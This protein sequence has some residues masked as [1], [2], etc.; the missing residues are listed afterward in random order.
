[1][2][3]CLWG[4]STENAVIG[5]KYFLLLPFFSRKCSFA[6]LLVDTE[7]D[8]KIQFLISV[9]VLYMPVMTVVCF[10]RTLQ[11]AN[12]TTSYK[13]HLQIISQI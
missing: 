9:L 6:V 7:K 4:L 2:M 8:D 12:Q 3:G 1:M 5:E 13:C 11:W 10:G